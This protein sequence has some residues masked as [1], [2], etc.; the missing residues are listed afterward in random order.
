MYKKDIGFVFAILKMCDDIEVYKSQHKNV[1]DI[2]NQR[3]GLN[4]CLMN[5]SQ[6]GE[7]TGKLSKE[8]KRQFDKIEWQKIKDLRNVIVHDYFELI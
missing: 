6:I 7:Y 8:F 5:I 3:M 1:Q 4:A 2:L